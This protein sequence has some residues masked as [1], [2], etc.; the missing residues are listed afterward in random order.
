MV[1]HQLFGRDRAR[2][3]KSNSVSYNRA[4]YP[5]LDSSDYAESIGCQLFSSSS[6]S[7]ASESRIGGEIRA[8][9]SA[10]DRESDNSQ[11]VAYCDVRSTLVESCD[12]VASTSA[13]TSSLRS[14]FPM[15]VQG[16]E[17]VALASNGARDRTRNSGLSG[18]G[19]F[20]CCTYR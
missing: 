16:V 6:I 1:K 4:R 19:A 20:G 14:N 3:R 5:P 17:L 13:V 7:S 2:D 18:R 15:T 11:F 9:K 12:Q 10:R 8:L